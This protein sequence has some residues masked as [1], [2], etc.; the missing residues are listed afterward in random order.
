[1]RLNFCCEDAKLGAMREKTE[2]R[3]ILSRLDKRSKGE[4]EKG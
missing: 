4:T 1:V 3:G 2:S